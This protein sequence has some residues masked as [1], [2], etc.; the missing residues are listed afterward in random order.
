MA[1]IVQFVFSEHDFL[2]MFMPINMIL[3]SLNLLQI[4]LQNK[5]LQTDLSQPV[6]TLTPMH[7]ICVHSTRISS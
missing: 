4:F 6:V 3:A 5:K 1:R 7:F 2:I